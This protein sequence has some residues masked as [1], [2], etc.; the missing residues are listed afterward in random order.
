LILVTK[1][2]QNLANNTLPGAKEA[3][4]EKLNAFIIANKPALDQ[5]YDK[6]VSHPEQGKL[7]DCNVPLP[8]LPGLVL[9]RRPPTHSM[10]CQVPL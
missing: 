5:F 9:I 10:D 7:A 8:P 6:M 4:M 1:V 2:L 3:Y